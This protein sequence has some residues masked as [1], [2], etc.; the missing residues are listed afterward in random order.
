MALSSNLLNVEVSLHEK[1]VI[2]FIESSRLDAKRLVLFL[3]I[4]DSDRCLTSTLMFVL[5]TMSYE[6]LRR[7][8]DKL[9]PYWLGN[10][11]I[12]NKLNNMLRTSEFLAKTSPKTDFFKIMPIEA[13]VS[14]LQDC[15][16]PGLLQNNSISS[17]RQAFLKTGPKE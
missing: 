10:Y 7:I 17:P 16:M 5:K 3:R 11:G 13:L 1:I 9:E 14:S 4:V 8:I 15:E 12:T 6:S 2:D